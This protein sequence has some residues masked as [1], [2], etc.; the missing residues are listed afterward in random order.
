[1]ATPLYDPTEG[2]T[3]KTTKDDMLDRLRK[4]K[5]VINGLDRQNKVRLQEIEDRI[6]AKG[7]PNEA[8]LRQVIVSATE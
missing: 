8:D 3:T 1:M 2:V 5:R 6:R 4:A 7:V